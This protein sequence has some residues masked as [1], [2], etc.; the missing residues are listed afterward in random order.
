MSGST[1]IEKKK[2]KTLRTV[3]SYSKTHKFIIWFG[4][5]GEEPDMEQRK[6]KNPTHKFKVL[7]NKQKKVSILYQ[8]N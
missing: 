5:W 2:K 1:K 3:L 4:L 8:V 7:F 6:K